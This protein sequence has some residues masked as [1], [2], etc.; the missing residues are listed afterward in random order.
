MYCLSALWCEASPDTR[1]FL[2]AVSSLKRLRGNCQTEVHPVGDGEEV[3]N[4]P[5]RKSNLLNLVATHKYS[6]HFKPSISLLFHKRFGIFSCLCC[7]IS[8][9]GLLLFSAIFYYYLSLFY[10]PSFHLSLPFRLLVSIVMEE[11]IPY[12][13]QQVF[14]RIIM[15]HSRRRKAWI[16]VSEKDK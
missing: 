1:A 11:V 3:S 13:K 8:C 6:S 5:S 14:P 10:M 15:H 4:H 16:T 9:I 12:F 2:D 7:M